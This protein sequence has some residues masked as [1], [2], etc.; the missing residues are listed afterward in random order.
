[1]IA[2]KAVA[3]IAASS[4]G[5]KPG[6]FEGG[7]RAFDLEDLLRVLAEVW[8]KHTFGMTYKAVL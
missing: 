2:G 6:F 4:R 5:K 1:M 8:G 7:A 3:I